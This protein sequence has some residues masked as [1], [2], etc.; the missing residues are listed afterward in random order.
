MKLLTDHPWILATGWTL[1][2]FLWQGGLVAVLLRLVLMLLPHRKAQLRY[3]VCAGAMGLLLAC[4]GGTYYRAATV[5]DASAG[6]TDSDD[7]VSRV[8]LTEGL[9]PE[10]PS[11]AASRIPSMAPYTKRVSSPRWAHRLQSAMP[12]IVCLWLAGTLFMAVRM[13]L[14]WR[15]VQQWRRTAQPV[16]DLH[17]HASVAKWSRQLGITKM[18]QL[19]STTAVNTPCVA[20]WFAPVIL[21]PAAMLAGF[22]LQQIESILVH[23][24]THIRRRDYLANLLQCVIETVFFFHPAVWHVSALMR[25]ERENCCDDTAAAHCGSLPYA[26]AL[27]ELATWQSHHLQAAPAATGGDLIQRLRRLTMVSHTRTTWWPAPTLIMLCLCMALWPRQVTARPD[28]SLEATSPALVTTSAQE[29]SPEW[30]SRLF[31]GIP[32]VDLNQ[33]AEKFKFSKVQRKGTHHTMHSRKI[34]IS[35]TAGDFSLFINK[36]RFKTSYPVLEK[37]GEGL[38]SLT[39]VNKVLGTVLILSRDKNE[40]PLS[41][42]TVVIDAGHGGA[43]SGGADDGSGY[44]KTY[45]LDTA[46]KLKAICEKQGLKVVMTRE[47]D[48]MVERAARVE[49]AA[50]VPNSIFVSL[51]FGYWKPEKRGCCTFSLTPAGTPSHPRSNQAENLENQPGNQHDAANIALA[52]SVHSSVIRSLGLVDLGLAR[53]RFTLLAEAAQPA[54]LIEPAMLSNPESAALIADDQWRQRLAEAIAAGITRYRQTTTSGR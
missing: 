49:I 17:W 31:D 32:Y 33:V 43:D 8:S 44:E 26:R 41:F 23:E 7:P 37:E 22:N 30:L 50:A 38:I 52:T 4:A 47:S 21:L 18:V 46:L 48:I 12:W 6:Y 34:N 2:H 25:Q 54:I 42:D 19:L 9:S 29:T 16:G 15:S 51:H 28:N 10:D 40:K 45:T 13:A 3:V 20:G 35:M 24:L 14:G 5:E 27:T 53:D 39:D 36:V 11:W 1:I